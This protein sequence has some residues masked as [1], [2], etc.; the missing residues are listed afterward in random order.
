MSVARIGSPGWDY[1]SFSITQDVKDPLCNPAT[2]SGVYFNFMV[3][4]SR[5][6][7]YQMDGETAVF[8]THEVYFQ[9]STDHVWHTIMVLPTQNWFCLV[10]IAPAVTECKVNKSVFGVY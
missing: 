5:T 2:V 9:D 3:T 7:G 10:P 4:I 8:P 1:L 6:G